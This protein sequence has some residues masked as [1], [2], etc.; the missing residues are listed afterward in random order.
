MRGYFLESKKTL[1]AVGYYCHNCGANMSLYEYMELE[2]PDLHREYRLEYFRTVIQP[3]QEQEKPKQPND[4]IEAFTA[5]FTASETVP[6]DV[7][8]WTPVTDLPDDHVINRY[9]RGRG[10]VNFDAFYLTYEFKHLSNLIYTGDPLF[11]DWALNHDQTRIVTDIILNGERQG[12]VGRALSKKVKPRY[13]ITKVTDD[14]KMIYN[15]DNVDKS[16]DVFVCEGVFD[17]EMLENAAAQLGLGKSL[18]PDDIPNRV[19]CLDNEPLNPDV[20]KRMLNLLNSGER[21]VDWSKLPSSIARYKDLNAMFTDGSASK[22]WLNTYV[23]NNIVSGQRGILAVKN[24]SGAHKRF[25]ETTTK[26]DIIEQFR[27]RNTS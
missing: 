7:L 23:R 5:K 20:Y 10:V 13:M 9:L 8:P 15:A 27:E 22:E 16:R 1:G 19:W 18:D 4:N 14:S 25:R 26:L 24:W 21:I 11:D 3:T 17:A 6:E 2:H 12:V